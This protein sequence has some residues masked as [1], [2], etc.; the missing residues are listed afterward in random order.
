[1]YRSSKAAPG[2]LLAAAAMLMI[3][4]VSLRAHQPPPPAPQPPQPAQTPAPTTPAARGATPAAPAAPAPKPLVPVA[5]NTI[6]ANPDAYYGQA[7]TITASVE[8]IF[9]KSSFTVDQRRVG[10]APAPTNPTD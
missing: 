1:M 4:F 5:T 10:D 8:Q 7:V 9:T 3:L 2:A 6:A